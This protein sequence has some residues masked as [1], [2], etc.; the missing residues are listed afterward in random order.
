RVVN[1]ATSPVN[2]APSVGVMFTPYFPSTRPAT[3]TV[4]RLVTGAVGGLMP[5]STSC[6]R[7]LPGDGGAGGGREVGLPRT[8]DPP[9]P[10]GRRARRESVCSWPSP[11]FTSAVK[12]AAGD[13][14]FSSSNTATAPVYGTP[15][16]AVKSCPRAVS[17]A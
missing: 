5:P 8:A 10:G 15:S 16:P 4:A 12:L 7:P 13:R 3:P 14:V 17:F 2:G 11:Q 1:Q 9:R 6:T